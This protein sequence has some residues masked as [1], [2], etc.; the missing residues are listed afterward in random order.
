MALQILSTIT[1]YVIFLDFSDA[2]DDIITRIAYRIH[3]SVAVCRPEWVDIG[4]ESFSRRSICGFEWRNFDQKFL[5]CE[6]FE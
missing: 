3:Y 4:R 1:S 6:V 5:R 2:D